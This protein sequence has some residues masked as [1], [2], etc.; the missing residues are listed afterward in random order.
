[1]QVQA[2]IAMK[3]PI[4]TACTPLTTMLQ[5]CVA[6]ETSTYKCPAQCSKHQTQGMMT[7][8]TTAT[9]T[10]ATPLPQ[11]ASAIPWLA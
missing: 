1:M 3:A 2:Y 9:S 5:P 10:A 7:L 11:S 6:A 8:A 4:H